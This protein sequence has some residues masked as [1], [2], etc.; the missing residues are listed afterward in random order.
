MRRLL[1]ILIVG[2]SAPFQPARPAAPAMQATGQV[3]GS[4]RLAG[5]QS[6]RPSLIWDDGSK[7]YL[8]WPANAE[9]PAVFAVDARGG[10]TL[11]NG[12]WRNGHYVIDAIYSRLIFRLDRAYARADRRT[13]VAA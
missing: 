4:Y 13:G 3:A 2:M 8:D 7:T 9:L 12:Y 10:E 6:V 1:L 5:D 11:V